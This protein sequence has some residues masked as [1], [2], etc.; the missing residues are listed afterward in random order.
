MV[1]VNEKKDFIR[2]FLNHYQ[3]KRRESKWI[4]EYIMKQD[5]LIEKLHFVDDI[6]GCQRAMLMSCH[7]VDTIPFKFFKN[8]SETIDAEKAFNDL[9]LYRDEDFYIKLN[10]NRKHTNSKYIRILE[11]NPFMKE[12]DESPDSGAAKDFLDYCLATFQREQLLKR[13]DEAIDN[14]KKKLFNKL[15]KE[16]NELPVPVKKFNT[17]KEKQLN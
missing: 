16:L 15:V 12:E 1:T 6:E 13:I 3:L 17:V 4:L 11:E 14:K 9:R 10:F 7:C 8:K 2:Y 5:D